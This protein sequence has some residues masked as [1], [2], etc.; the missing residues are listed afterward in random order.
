VD[1]VWTWECAHTHGILGLLA[2][3]YPIGRGIVE[4]ACKLVVEGRMKG[5]GMHWAVENI[6]PLLA[7]RGRLC[8]RQWTQTWPAIQREWH[9]Q[10]ATRRKEGGSSG[11]PDAHEP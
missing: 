3:G 11:S 10:V 8:S 7:L 4:S 5:S 1:S 6:N 2:Q 9:M